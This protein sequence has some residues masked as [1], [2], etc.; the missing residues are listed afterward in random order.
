MTPNKPKTEE[1]NWELVLYRLDEIKIEIKEM[2][3]E[4]VTKVE[5]AALKHEIEELR[6]EIAA[7]KRS[8]NL[9]AWLSPTLTAAF[10]ATFTYL[11]LERIKGV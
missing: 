1:P 2:K 11:V 5:S 4:Y 9:W 3:K 10:T 7:I 6:T 8:K